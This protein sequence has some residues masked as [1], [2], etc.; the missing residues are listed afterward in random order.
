MQYHYRFF[1]T[2]RHFFAKAHKGVTLVEVLVALV[3]FSFGIL[4]L[5]G[6]QSKLLVYNQSTLF[7]S[8]AVALTDD[9]I[10]RMRLDP[11]Q[12]KSVTGPWNTPLAQNAAELTALNPDL[13]AW[14]AQVQALLP[15]GQASIVV[16]SNSEI[17]VTIQW[18]DERSSQQNN[19]S[20]Q[21]FVT[22]SR[23]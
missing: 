2:A 23:I 1:P 3:L 18:L 10:E 15:S 8:Q 7:R 11:V 5:V 19:L 9:V 13:S 17:V 12:S 22:L 16:K 20:V 14:K 21:Q 6:F 4:G